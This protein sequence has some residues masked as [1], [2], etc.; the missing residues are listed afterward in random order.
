[1]KPFLGFRDIEFLNLL[2]IIEARTPICC[3]HNLT[4]PLSEEGVLHYT[5]M[6]SDKIFPPQGIHEYINHFLVYGNM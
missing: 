6:L 5:H 4:L 2:D 1:M 3:Y